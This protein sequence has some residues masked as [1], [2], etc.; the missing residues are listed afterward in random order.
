M[1]VPPVGGMVKGVALRCMLVD[2]NDSFLEAARHLLEADGIEVVAAV[3]TGTEAV[4]RLAGLRPDVVLVD[5]RLG[6]ESG[7]DV[8]RRLLDEGASTPV[9]LISTH[10]DLQELATNS[11]AAGWLWKG[12]IT[13]ATVRSVV[14]HWR[15]GGDNH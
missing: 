7:L 15:P 14:E 8:A 4:A 1:R 11:G 3:T 2:D 12:E 10:A 13:G 6:D 5:V 9:I